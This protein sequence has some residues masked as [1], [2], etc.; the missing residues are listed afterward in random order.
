[1]LMP[2]LHAVAELS[3]R[4][5][6]CCAACSGRRVQSRVLVFKDGHPS[7]VRLPSPVSS[8]LATMSRRSHPVALAEADARSVETVEHR[9]SDAPSRSSVSPYARCLRRPVKNLRGP[10]VVKHGGVPILARLPPTPLAS[11][12]SARALA[13][14]GPTHRCIGFCNP[15]DPRTRSTLLA[16]PDNVTFRPRLSPVRVRNNN[17]RCCRQIG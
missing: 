14:L 17:S 7:L 2:G 3:P 8:R 9:T 5:Q 1:M 10:R 15:H 13:R 12:A 6:R 11:T 4:V 16:P